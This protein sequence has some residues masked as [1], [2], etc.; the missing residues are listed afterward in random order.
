MILVLIDVVVFFSFFFPC[1]KIDC[2]LCTAWQEFVYVYVSILRE[3]L[4]GKGEI[5]LEPFI[6]EA[7]EDPC[8]IKL[9]VPNIKHTVNEMF[10]QVIV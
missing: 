3:V 6:T 2:L 4:G 1:L 8:N 10:L 7:L 5:I 9:L